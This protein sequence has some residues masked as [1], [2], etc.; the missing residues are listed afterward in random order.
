MKQLIQDIHKGKNLEKNLAAYKEQAVRI[1]SNYT[2]LELT[3][4]AYVL[5]EGLQEEQQNLAVQEASMVEPVLQALREL[6]EGARSCGDIQQDMERLRRDIAERMDFFTAYTDRLICYEYVLNRMELKYL[7]EKELNKELSAFDE[8]EY[9]KALMLYLF[10]SEDQ[11]VI[12]DKIHTVVGQIPVHMTKNKLF[13]KI[14]EA[15]SLHKGGSRQEL[16]TF[17]YMMKT[18]AM[19]YEPAY[20]TGGYPA[21][22]EPVRRLEQADYTALTEEQYK[23]LVT[24]LGQAGKAIHELT[25]FY[26]SLQKVVNCIYAMCLM[27]PYSSEESRLVKAGKAIWCCLARREYREEMLIPLEGRIEEYVGQSSYLESVLFEIKASYKEELKKFGLT[28]FFS[29]AAVT[30]N[31]LSDSLFIDLELAAEEEPVEEAYLRKKQEELFDE[32]SRKFSGVSRP[33]KRAIMGKLLEKLPMFPANTGEMEEYIRI[34]L[35]GCQD[36]AEK[37]IVLMILWDIMQEEREWREL[38]D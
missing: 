1:Y 2:M 4:S 5:V 10:Q 23:E 19:I 28:G 38:L 20:E 17:L 11:S 29:D 12:R 36:K 3:F 26:Y 8:E 35:F 24:L 27:L 15:I 25:D 16:E 13:E 31:L 7:P 14:G 9:F 30:A 6:G 21:F 32:L 33:V 34:N 18:S 22:E 37:C